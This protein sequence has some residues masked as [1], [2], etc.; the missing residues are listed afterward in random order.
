MCV[1]L[2]ALPFRICLEA[3]MLP[4]HPAVSQTWLAGV[5]L[6]VGMSLARTPCHMIPGLAVVFTSRKHMEVLLPLPFVFRKAV[7]LLVAVREQNICLR[8]RS[9]GCDGGV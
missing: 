8:R 6:A 3:L 9:G 7:G 5:F 1:G 4:N 2:G